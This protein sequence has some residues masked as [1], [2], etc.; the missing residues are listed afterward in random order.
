MAKRLTLQLRGA[1]EDDEHVRLSDF[2]EELEAVREALNAIDERL[3]GHGDRTTDYRVVDLRHS[4]PA[5][6][7]LESFAIDSME[8]HSADVVDSFLDSI[9][10]INEGI[11]PPKLDSSLLKKLGNIASPYHKNVREVVFLADNQE[12]IV[13]PTFEANIITIVGEDSITDG[14]LDGMLEMI[15]LHR[16]VNR[17]SIYPTI[18]PGKV[19]CHFSN[20]LSQK[21]IESVGRHIRVSGKLKLK[22]IDRYP[23]GIE[24]ESIEILPADADLPTFADIYGIAP[25]FTEGL[26]SVEFIRAIRNA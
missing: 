8:D 26:S 7:V 23:Y 24:V 25:D 15:N 3:I 22:K 17:F 14:R 1:M 16:G 18:G 11:A 12:I 2:V 4:S 9:R 13:S 10:Q 6:V 20:E 5:S 21:A 19:T